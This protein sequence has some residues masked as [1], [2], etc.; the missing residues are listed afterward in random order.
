M[1]SPVFYRN[2][3]GGFTA[4]PKDVTK[5]LKLVANLKNISEQEVAIKTIA[6]AKEFFNLA[7]YG[8]G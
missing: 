7:K 6:N 1:T 5:T 2:D 8:H 4:E 3:Q